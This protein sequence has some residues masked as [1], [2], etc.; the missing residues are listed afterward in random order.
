VERVGSQFSL[1]PPGQNS[2]ISNTHDYGVDAGN[3]MAFLH[4][5]LA[6]DALRLFLDHLVGSATSYADA[7]SRVR[8]RDLSPVDQE[9]AKNDLQRFRMSVFVAKRMSEAVAVDETYKT[10][11]HM[12]KK[13]PKGFANDQ[14]RANFPG[15]AVIGPQW[16]KQPFIVLGVGAVG[17]QDL[18]R[19]L[20]AALAL[21]NDSDAASGRDRAPERGGDTTAAGVFY[22]G[23]GRYRVANKGLR[24]RH[25]CDNSDI[26]DPAYFESDKTFAATS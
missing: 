1:C 14:H 15:S 8:S 9:R 6:G 24:I 16:A 26:L 25:I 3:K 20:Q 22:H 13:M 5:I 18:Y 10:V 12:S 2:G 4:I 11:K 19:E 7:C 23:Q 21:K 17:F